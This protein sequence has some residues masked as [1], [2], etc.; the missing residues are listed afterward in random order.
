MRLF[1][2]G[3]TVWLLTV[4][5]VLP[6]AGAAFAQIE[7]YTDNPSYWQYNDRPIF[8]FGGSNR[9]NIFHWAGD[10]TRLTDHLDL[11]KD[12]GGNYIRCTIIRIVVH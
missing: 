12:C 1:R 6:S 4:A 3:T 10:G 9:D 7:P 5:A 8:F 11:L 2:R